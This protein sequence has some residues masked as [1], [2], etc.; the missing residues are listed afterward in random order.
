M[1]SGMEP[2]YVLY[3]AE[4]LPA[5]GL[6]DELTA[7][8]GGPLGFPEP[9]L[10]ANFVAT[11]DGIVAIPGVARSNRLIR[12]GSDADRFVMGLLR[13]CADVVL[14]GS[15]TLHGSRTL[16]IPERA[17]PAASPAFSELRRRRGQPPDPLLAVVTGSGAL[18][19]DHAALAAGALVLTTD[20]GAERL[21]GRVPS[22]CEIVSLGPGTSV[23]LPDA[24]A[25]LRAR[26]HRLILSEAGPRVFG[27]LLAARLVDELFLTSSPVL[28]GRTPDGTHLG[29]VEGTQLLPG[30]AAGRLLGIR[31]Q[32]DHV[33]ARYEFNPY[34]EQPSS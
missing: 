32:G 34:V 31:R 4:G 5:Y 9:R 14:I 16:W 1:A 18:D 10:V 20:I 21:G 11:L 30:A 17:F 3:E 7:L 27:S 2:L 6:P 13:A 25:A 24:V 33:L 22:A 12:A 29:L 15:G 26:G 8:Y 28:A 19:R 23:D